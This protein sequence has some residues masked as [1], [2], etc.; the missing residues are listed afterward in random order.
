MAGFTVSD[1]SWEV[2]GLTDLD[3]GEIVTKEHVAEYDK[4]SN[5]EKAEQAEEQRRRRTRGFIRARQLSDAWGGALCGL[6]V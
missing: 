5:K 1:C 3:M 4:Q 6:V 2:A